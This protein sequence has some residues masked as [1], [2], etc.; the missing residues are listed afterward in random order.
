MTLIVGS[1]LLEDVNDSNQNVLDLSVNEEMTRM[2]KHYEKN[3]GR[4]NDYLFE[5][6]QFDEKY[7]E[8]VIKLCV[9]LINSYFSTHRTCDIYQALKT[10][11]AGSFP[12]N[13]GGDLKTN[14]KWDYNRFHRDI[15]SNISKLKVLCPKLSNIPEFQASK[16]ILTTILSFYRNS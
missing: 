16:D 2:L 8:I 3:I 9:E 13:A 4:R 6:V 11:Q 7:K 1:I 10:Y 14:L 5:D 12:N 15:K